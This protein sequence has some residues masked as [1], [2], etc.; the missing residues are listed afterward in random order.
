M[1]L[2]H[3]GVAFAAKRAAPQASLGILVLA[4]QL[5]DIV[6]PLLLL[7][8]IEHV[9]VTH[10]QTPLLDLVFDSYPYSHSL[11]VQIGVGVVLAGIYRWRRGSIRSAA[12]VGLLVPSHWVL[13]WLVHVPDLPLLP[14]D[15]DRFGLGMWQSL[16]AT[17]ACE[18]AV[19]GVGTFIYALYTKALDGVGRWAFVG[20]TAFLAVIYAASLFGGTPP[21][22]NVVAWSALLLWLLPPWALWFDRHRIVQAAR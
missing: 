18:T 8:G 22:A 12:V 14:G 7:A 2:G 9:H 17:L 3:F 19:F 4:A 6:W 15:P 10:G 13:D 11:L 20:Y 1:F 5:A 16:P 21:S